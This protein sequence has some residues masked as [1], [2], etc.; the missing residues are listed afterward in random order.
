MSFIEKDTI[1]ALDKG[2]RPLTGSAK[3]VFQ[4]V[5]FGVIADCHVDSSEK[6]IEYLECTIKKLNQTEELNCVVFNGDLLRDGEVENARAVREVLASLKAEACV[7][8]GNHDF[9]PADPEKIIAGTRYLEPDD[10]ISFF[11][12][13]GYDGLNT[14]FYAK[15]MA[16]GLRL[17]A[18]DACLPHEREKWGGILPAEQL[19]WLDTQ[20]SSHADQVNLVFI[21]HGLIHWIPTDRED[22]TKKW[23]RIDNARD[24]QTVLEK[25]RR[26]T[27]I[28]ISG[29]RHIGLHYCELRGVN[30]FTVPPLLSPA[31]RYTMF[32]VTPEQISW[33]SCS[34]SALR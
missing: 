5:R 29:H 23:Y 32:T 3:T 34:L 14:P 31:P 7:L 24:V 25:N 20:L 30:Y 9:R 28:A 15:Q 13:F 12:G 26:A 18:L 6:G 10:F 4:P 21:H 22:E 2:C 16:P 17:L 8:R 11:R 27:P 33:E 1:L 19:D